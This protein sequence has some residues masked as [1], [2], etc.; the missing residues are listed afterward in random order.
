MSTSPD[1][2]A[3]SLGE[4]NRLLEAQ[5]IELGD[6]SALP[7]GTTARECSLPPRFSALFQWLGGPRPSRPFRISPSFPQIENL[8][9]RFLDRHLEWRQKFWL[10][11]ALC[12]VWIVS[13]SAISAVSERSCRVPGYKSPLRLSCVSRPW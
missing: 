10:L 4:G 7:G 6:M 5:G 12:L 11:L 1:D 2:D 9:V 13:F 8:P 3:L